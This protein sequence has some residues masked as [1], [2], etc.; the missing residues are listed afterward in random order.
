M[1]MVFILNVLRPLTL[2]VFG[3]S[4]PKNMVSGYQTDTINR[5]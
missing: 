1:N 4:V 5:F 2:C 3:S